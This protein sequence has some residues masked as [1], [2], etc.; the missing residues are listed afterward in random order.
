MKPE[1]I[2]KG[3]LLFAAFASF[4]L[5]VTIYFNAGDNTNGRLN[6]IFIGIWVPS[7]LAL[8]TFLLS[9]RKTP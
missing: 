4:L 1:V 3:T 7:I 9:H 5:S 8:G 6:G 2:L